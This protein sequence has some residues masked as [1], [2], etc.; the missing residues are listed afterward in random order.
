MKRHRILT[1]LALSCLGLLLTACGMGGGGGSDPATATPES[2]TTLTLA[3][4]SFEDAGGTA[5]YLN[6]TVTT[7]GI[8][9]VEP[10]VLANNKL[11]VFIQ[12]GG[13]GIMVYHENSGAVN[14]ADFAVGNRVRVTGTVRQADPSSGNNAAVGTPLIDISGGSWSVVSAGND[15]PAPRVVTLN[16]LA[17]NGNDYDGT[18]V[19]AIEVHKVAGSWPVVG[20]QSKSVTVSDGTANLTLR[21]QKNTITAEMAARLA[22]IGNGAFHLVA[23]ATQDDTNGDGDLLDGFQLWVRGV[24]DIIEPANLVRQAAVGDTVTAEGVVTVA[25]GILFDNK[26][27]VFIQD[28]TGGLMLLNTA[29]G[30]SVA[31]GDLVRCTGTLANTDASGQPLTGTLRIDFTNSG[32]IEV[33]SHGNPLP[34]PQVVTLAQYL[35]APENYEGE[36]IRINGASKTAGNWPAV[37]VKGTITISDDGGAT[38]AKLQVQKGANTVDLTGTANPFDVVGIAVHNGASWEVWIRSPEDINPL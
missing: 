24:D 10:G 4:A 27:E 22:A 37:G 26:F 23:I 21:F 5:A 6:R 13:A 3:E 7:E 20:D 2:A 34:A 14:A 15:L 35:A 36:L 18:L 28:S 30:L 38:T 12:D 8:V 11:K 1:I 9:T 19:N 17:A 16:E 29:G 32:T 25:S 33:L 31:E